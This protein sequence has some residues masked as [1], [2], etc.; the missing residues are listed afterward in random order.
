MKKGLLVILALALCFSA[1]CADYMLPGPQK[2][3]IGITGKQNYTQPTRSDSCYYSFSILPMTLQ[4]SYFDYMI[5][6]YNDLPL[7]VEPDPLYGGYF[8]TYMGQRTP[9]GQRRVFYSY[10]SDT[11]VIQNNNELTNVQNYE[12]FSS[13]DVDPVSGKP[14]Y[15]WHYGLTASAANMDVQYAYDAFLAGAA[16][17]ISDPVTVINAPITYPAPYNSTDNEFIWPTVQIGPS[18]TAGMRRVYVLGRNYAGH[19]DGS[20][21]ASE[22]A[23]IAYADFNGDMFEMGTP[24]IW[25]HVSIPVLDNWNH[26]TGT[27]NQARRP[28]CAFAVSN[29]GHLYYMGIH[30]AYFCDTEG[31]IVEP[32]LDV[33]VCDNYGQGTWS[34]VTGSSVYKSWNPQLNYG[35]GAGFFKGTDSTTPV[36]SDSLFWSISNSAHMNSVIDSE[37]KIHS[38]NIW[39]QQFREGPVNDLGSWFHGTLQTVKDLIYDTN[40]STFSF[41]EIYPIAGT[42]SDTLLWRP[43]DKNG[44]WVTDEYWDDPEDP[45]SLGYPKMTST[46]PF[47]YWDDTVH[48]NGMYFHYSNVKITEPN[49]QGMMAAVWSESNRA[50]LYNENP[51][52]Y[53]ELAQFADVPEIWISFTQDLG[54]TWTEPFSLNKIETPQLAGMK[55]MWV[56]PANKIKYTTTVD[57]HKMGKLALM[58]YDDISW[59]SYQQDPPVGQNDGGYVKFMELTL[60]YPVASEDPINKPVISMLQQNFPNPFNPETT[61]SFSIPKSGKANLSIYNTKGQLVKTLVDGNVAKGAQQLT[62]KGTDNNGKRVGSGL[63]FYKLNTDG[64]VET[65]KMML[66]K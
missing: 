16:G 26:S 21:N 7:C 3:S 44:D 32:D 45:E 55:P 22:N 28:M 2:H 19:L 38:A 52:S 31:D 54:M 8:M 15:A 10:I 30:V 41:R 56:Y 12:G 34:R 39:T 61:I 23:W 51:A 66:M 49:E 62:W 9:N 53:P 27:P 63:Y 42:P 47:P 43:W 64:K 36:P 18:P 1:V 33:F 11:G 37:G 5:G 48:A 14:I 59:G 25:N 29:D 13:M 46:F 20:A 60:N 40:T 50:R 57:G 24:L 17:L 65:R 6:G 4:T 35:A 58:F